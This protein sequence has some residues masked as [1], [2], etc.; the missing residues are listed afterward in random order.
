MNAVSKV[1]N[2]TYRIRV[3][4]TESL[5]TIVKTMGEGGLNGLERISRVKMVEMTR[6]DFIKF[7]DKE[8]SEHLDSHEQRSILVERGFNTKKVVIFSQDNDKKPDH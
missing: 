3:D 5:E 2:I 1:L 6:F 7:A 8:C 4:S